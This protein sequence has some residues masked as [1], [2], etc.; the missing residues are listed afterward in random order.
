MKK[1]AILLNLGRGGIVNEGDLARAL[2][3]GLIA[4]AGLDVFEQEPMDAKNPL[5][6][7]KNPE[8]LVL[9]PHIAWTSIEARQ[10][11]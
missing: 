11:C 7:L 2:D 9:T 8:R 4:G 1:S 3:E 6:N 10:P 5:L